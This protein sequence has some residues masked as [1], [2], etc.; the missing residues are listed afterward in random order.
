MTPSPRPRNAG[1]RLIPKNGRYLVA[2]LVGSP[3][4][5]ARE[6]RDKLAADRGI[7][8]QYH[9]E[10]THGHASRTHF[11]TI[12]AD[13]DL[14][15]VVITQTSHDLTAKAVALARRAETLEGRSIPVVRV[16]HKWTT[17]CN[18]LTTRFRIMKS[19]PLPLNVTSVAYFRKP[20]ESVI[21]GATPAPKVE[22]PAPAVSVVPAAPAAPPV[23]PAAAPSP[24]D[25]LAAEMELRRKFLRTDTLALI[26]ELQ[27]RLPLAGVRSILISQG[28][29]SFDTAP[30]SSPKAP[31][32][33]RP[34]LALVGGQPTP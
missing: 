29:V 17:L 30:V 24:A 18:N 20:P 22:I 26:R 2:L 12:P 32:E 15:L 8:V 3:A 25:V 9:V 28:D 27:A 16:S 23:A 7:L 21:S 13:V 33:P 14:V 1:E 31:T 4:D 6:L 19:A 11:K 34:G 5:R 10:Y